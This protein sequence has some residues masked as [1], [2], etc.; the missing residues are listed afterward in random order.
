MCAGA[1]VNSRLGKLVYGCAD[2]RAGA[3]GGSPLEILNFPGMLHQV[4]VTGGVCADECLEL[5]RKFFAD[6]R[7][8]KK[9]EDQRDI[10]P[11]NLSMN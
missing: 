2:P 4:K 5:L 10:W 3:A 11:E 6:R 8:R 1:M 7:S 9:S